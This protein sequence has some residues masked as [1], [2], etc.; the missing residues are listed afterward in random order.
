MRSW[1]NSA[2]FV[3]VC[4]LSFDSF[5]KFELSKTQMTLKR[6]AAEFPSLGEVRSISSKCFFIF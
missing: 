1:I 2:E 5:L 3:M 4:I 6:Y